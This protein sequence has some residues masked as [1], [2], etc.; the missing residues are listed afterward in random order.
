M[1]QLV[2]RIGDDER[3]HMAWGTFTCRRHVA[4]DDAN[5]Q[6]VQDEISR[7][8][9][10]ALR[11]IT[12]AYEEL[13]REWPGAG[14]PFDLEMDVFVD[15]AMSKGMRRIGTIESARGRPLS[16]IDVDSEPIDLEDR[17][18]AEDDRAHAEAEAASA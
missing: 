11:Q 16:E 2:R 7:L 12:W 3:R 6:I 1:Q 18:G 13:E 9:Q 10:P 17:F 5:W 4:A 14:M 8:I 15:Y